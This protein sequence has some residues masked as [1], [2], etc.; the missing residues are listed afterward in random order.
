MC[1]DSLSDA[2]FI[3]WF[4]K[5]VICHTCKK[6]NNFLHTFI[7]AKMPLAITNKECD[8]PMCD[9]TGRKFAIFISF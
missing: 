7:F 6:W 5:K 4:I 1:I 9:L 3:D 2:H 8:L